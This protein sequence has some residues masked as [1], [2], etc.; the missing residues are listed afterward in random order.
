MFFGIS[1]SF[2]I[3]AVNDSLKQGQ[4]KKDVELF[5]CCSLSAVKAL[6][7]L[8]NDKVRIIHAQA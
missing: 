2:T 1:L 7:C 4:N 8:R 3:G 6:Q 5:F